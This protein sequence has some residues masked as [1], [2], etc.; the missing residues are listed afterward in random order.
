MF[1]DDIEH[2][3]VNIAKKEVFVMFNKQKVPILKK[4]TKSSCKMYK[5]KRETIERFIDIVTKNKTNKN[6]VKEELQL[7]MK[8]S[9]DALNSKLEY[10]QKTLT[11]K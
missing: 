9:I 10:L 2:L 8:A 1:L 7:E 6:Q 11:E 4:K 5:L 3:C